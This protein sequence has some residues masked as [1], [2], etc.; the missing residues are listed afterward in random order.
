VL[1]NPSIAPKDLEVWGFVVTEYTSNNT[2]TVAA[3]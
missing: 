3:A 2:G 1:R